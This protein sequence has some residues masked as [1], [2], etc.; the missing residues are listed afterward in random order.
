M[1]I[2]IIADV[3]GD[4]NNG[5]TTACMNLIRYLNNIGDEV[6]VVCADQG[7]IGLKGYYIVKNYNLGPL[8]KILERNNVNLAKADK[9]IMTEAITGC[10]IIHVMLP[11]ALGIAATKIAKEL[12][13]PITSGFHCQAENITS[14]FGVMNS[15]GINTITYKILYDKFYSHVDAI[16]YPTKFIK[17]VFESSCNHE[18]NGY[19]ISNGVHSR[20]IKKNVEKPKDLQEKF[21]I[22][23]TGRF[24]K[25]KSHIIL[26]KAV[27]NSKY[28]DKIQLIFAGQGPL[29][30]R[31]INYSKKHLTNM[32]ILNF[33]PKDELVDVINYS[34]LY[35][36]PAEVEIEAIACLEAIS[37]GIVPVIADSKKCATKNFALNEN[38]LFICNDYIDLSN[39]IDYW[40]EH[41]KEKEECS[42]N[43]LN[44]TKQFAQ[45][46]CMKKM[47]EMFN[48]VIKNHDSQKDN[49]L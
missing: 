1:L 27:N 25:E 26:L 5:T 13:I 10:D 36:H 9:K 37:C 6:R 23:F 8:N 18:T 20:F 24:S 32:P 45:D 11:F 30:N 4:E 41:P 44:Y 42:N 48:E 40:I 21:I 7:K 33:Y 22:L 12:N 46:E 17:D 2:C 19:V 34:D 3:L 16:H 28:K 43:Y 39:K 38:N 47:K 29:K 31:I 14:H 49:L 35:V 15:D